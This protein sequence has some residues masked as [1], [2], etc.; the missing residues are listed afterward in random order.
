MISYLFV[1][2]ESWYVLIPDENMIFNFL[3]VPLKSTPKRKPNAKQRIDEVIANVILIVLVIADLLLL[4]C[5][6]SIIINTVLSLI[7]YEYHHLKEKINKEQT[8]F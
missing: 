1:V 5:V 2:G 6:K 4:K 7:G 8:E 3:L